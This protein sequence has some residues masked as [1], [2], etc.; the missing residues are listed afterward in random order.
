[1]PFLSMPTAVSTVSAADFNPA[2]IMPVAVIV[3]AG[4]IGLLF[5]AF[6][7]RSSRH[8]A[9]TSLMVASLL[10]A[11]VLLV[12][13]R[14]IM[15][16]PTIAGS[17]VIDGPGWLLQLVIAVTSLLALVLAAERFSGRTADAF[18]EAGSSVPGSPQEALA[19]RE[20][21]STELYPLACFCVAGMMLFVAAGDLLTLFVGL[22]MFSLPLYVLVSMGRRRRLL[23][24]EASLKYFLLGSFASAFFLFGSALLFG[25]AG[26]LNLGTIALAMGSV[27]GKGPLLVIGILLV[28]SGMLFKVGAAPFQ[29]WTADVYQGAPTAVTAFMSAVVKVAAFGALMRVVYVAFEGARWNFQAV[30]WV[31]AGLTMVIG[32]ILTITQSDIKRMLAYSSV[33]HAGFILVGLLAFDVRGVVGVM[34]YLAAYAFTTISAFGLVMLVRVRGVEATDLS[35]WAGLGRKHPVIAGSMGFVLLSFAGIPLTSGFTAKVAAFG[36]AIGAAGAPGVT[37]AVIG[38]LCSA[39]TAFVYFRFVILMFFADDANDEVSVVAPSALTQAS[40]ALGL[41]VTIVLGV[42]PSPALSLLE[43]ASIFIR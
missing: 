30:M 42:M 28:L 5:E 36:A 23:S 34:F 20:G 15:T 33:A 11:I 14:P 40:I 41:L 25:Y 43:S 27:A 7:N 2:A 17:L 10:F 39:V 13:G 22:E 19:A 9:Q 26:S 35:Q 16:G 12:I 18:T 24:Q 6:M 8:T 1:M 29:W 31:V 4:F 37:L 21:S 32:T 38:V 3:L